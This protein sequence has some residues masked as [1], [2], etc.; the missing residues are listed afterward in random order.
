MAASPSPRHW[1]NP[2]TTV[3]FAAVGVTGILTWPGA[4]NG[5]EDAR[6]DTGD[7]PDSTKAGRGDGGGVRAAP[8]ATLHRTGR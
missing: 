4:V 3:F 8:W 7:C 6:G 5:R 2:L 1:L